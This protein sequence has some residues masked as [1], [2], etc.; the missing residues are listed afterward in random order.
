M[1]KS[2]FQ[3]WTWVWEPALG[4]IEVGDKHVEVSYE[5]PR[6]FDRDKARGWIPVE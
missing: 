4:G 1:A 5:V 3:R 6:R 2:E